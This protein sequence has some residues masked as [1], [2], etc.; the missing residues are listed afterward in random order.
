MLPV[1]LFMPSYRS[2]LLQ[3]D[4]DERW[5]QIVA[6]LQK[7]LMQLRP[8]EIS[9]IEQRLDNVHLL[10]R[11]LH[12]LFIAADGAEHCSNCA[13]QCCELGHNHMTLVNV[14][15]CLLNG[16]LPPVNFSNSCPFLAH[17]GCSLA[18]EHRPFN[19]V[20]F[21]CDRVEDALGS[22][23]QQ[24]FYALEAE[25]RTLYTAFDERYLGSSMRGILI[26]SQRI[27]GAPFLTLR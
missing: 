6:A 5:R 27:N 11:R 24:Q 10:Q 14:I 26:R 2:M 16:D 18:V 15:S 4:N 25:L 20:T 23:R 3:P 7:E 22:E 8:D 17:D 12:Q 13:G 21:I 9:W 19:C 1:S